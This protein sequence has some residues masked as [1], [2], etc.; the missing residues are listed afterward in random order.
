MRV[1]GGLVEGPWGLGRAP[2]GSW[3]LGRAPGR[4]PGR[5][6]RAHRRAPRAPWDTTRA[7]PGYT[8]HA[9]PGTVM[10]APRLRHVDLEVSL[11]SVL[12]IQCGSSRTFRECYTLKN[13]SGPCSVRDFHGEMAAHRWMSELTKVK[14]WIGSGP[15]CR[16]FLIGPHRFA[17]VTKRVHIGDI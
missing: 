10:A 13:E 2:G 17:K 5:A 16:G 7:P 11:G 15:K 8:Y 12:P 14:D 6:R 9:P 1:P 4:V 3:R